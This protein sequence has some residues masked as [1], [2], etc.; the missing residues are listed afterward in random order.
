MKK[1]SD[2]HVYPLMKTCS[3]EKYTEGS[4]PKSI[5]LQYIDIYPVGKNQLSPEPVLRFENET[6]FPPYVPIKCKFY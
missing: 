1:M 2:F 5:L 4:D 6:L 3:S